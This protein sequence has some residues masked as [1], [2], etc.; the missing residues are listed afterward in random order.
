LESCSFF[1]RVISSLEIASSFYNG[2]LQVDTL[3][4]C[5]ISPFST[6]DSEF[7]TYLISQQMLSRPS[8]ER[9]T[10]QYASLT[11]FI[12]IS[13]Y[14]QKSKSAVGV[15]RRFGLADRLGSGE[16]S[17][18]RKTLSLPF[19]MR[20]NR[21]LI[22]FANLCHRN[23]A[24]FAQDI[25]LVRTGSTSNPSESSSMVYGEYLSSRIPESLERRFHGRLS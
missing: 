5:S 19:F 13:S 11:C 8:P 4:F 18:S 21:S 12:G 14:R 3:A 2:L 9:E 6:G 20:E 16:S 24:P 17:I 23:P 7:P 1:A 22:R 10:T 15:I 25:N